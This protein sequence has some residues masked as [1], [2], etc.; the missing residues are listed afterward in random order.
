MDNYREEFIAKI[1]KIPLFIP[2]FTT[3]TSVYGFILLYSAAGGHIE[4][5]AYKQILIF[6]IFMPI[7][8]LIAIIDLRIIYNFAYTF[9]ITT[10]LL[11]LFVELMGKSVM[12]A[13]RWLDLGFFTIQPSELVKVSVVMMLAKF[14]H[15]QNSSN[16]SD[17]TLILPLIASIIP[18]ALVIK[19]PDLGTGMITLIV[20]CFM[21]FAAGVKRIYFIISAVVGLAAMPA[22][23]FM[24]YDY[25]RSRILTFIDPEADPL[26]KGYNIIQSKIA[27][28][29]GGLFGKGLL[30]GTQGPLSFLPEYE[31]D[32][33]F[34]FLTEELGF[35]GGIMLL[36]L[37]SL[38]I[39]SSLSVAINC[40]SKFAKLLTI[41]IVT[42]FFCHIFINIAMVMGL[43]PA[44]GVPLPLI[45]YG[46]TMMVSM[47]LGFGLIMNAAVNRHKNL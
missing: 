16:A 2:L 26:G 35:M 9:Y 38:I 27:I 19:Q 36:I 42:L 39:I 6:L 37:Y 11:L 4:P 8:I 22:I 46:R 1:K 40:R 24:L 5:W 23:W 47:L 18:I 44:V 31:T 7:S 10:L 3:L 29:S 25:Q 14:F 28:G 30:S 12:G 34:S 15:E 21:F 45:S 32:F 33:I 17:F 43:L 41:G 13:T 20:V